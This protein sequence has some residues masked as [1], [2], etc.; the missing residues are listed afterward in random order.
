MGAPLGTDGRSC[1]GP[2]DDA[3]S[4]QGAQKTR[5]QQLCSSDLCVPSTDLIDIDLLMTW[6]FRPPIAEL[7]A[8]KHSQAAGRLIISGKMSGAEV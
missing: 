3:V 4:L 2:D 8:G 1:E 7:A 6:R 5:N